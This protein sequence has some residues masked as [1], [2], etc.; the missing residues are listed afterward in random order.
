MKKR[1]IL[2]CGI[3]GAGKSTWIKENLAELE[4][5]G[6]VTV[7]SRDK[8]RFSMV[9]EDEEYFSKEKMVY[10]TFVNEIKRGLKESD[11]TIA[12]ATHLNYHSRGKILNSLGDSLEGVN[13]EI[14]VVLTSLSK[15]LEQNEL[16]KGT[17]AY[18][19]ENSLLNMSNNFISPTVEEGFDIIYKK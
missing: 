7:V 6:S 8:I 15:C 14:I 13:K 9:K 1:L 3:P 12:D 19:P 17:R 11:I 2:M 16:R 4:K 5:L 18:V 10:R